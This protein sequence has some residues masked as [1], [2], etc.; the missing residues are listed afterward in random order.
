[1]RALLMGTCMLA[2][3][4]AEAATYTLTFEERRDVLMLDWADE[5]ESWAAFRRGDGSFR[6]VF[7]LGFRHDG[8]LSGTFLLADL[9]GLPDAYSRGIGDPWDAPGGWLTLDAGSVTAWSIGA[10]NA[11]V[12][13]YAYEW[14][15][16]SEGAALPTTYGEWPTALDVALWAD[17]LQYGVQYTEPD[18]FWFNLGPGRWSCLADGTP[19]AAVAGQVEA[20]THAPLPGSMVLLVGALGGLLWAGRRR[21]A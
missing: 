21:A 3:G 19:C 15:H 14:G 11:G 17:A 2:F 18:Y 7:E 6:P 8:A 12:G 16:S 10:Y 9:L 5:A 13:S 20:P 4:A 1:M